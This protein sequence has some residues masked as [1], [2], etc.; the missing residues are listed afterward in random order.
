MNIIKTLSL[1]YRYTFNA[2][3]K[4]AISERVRMLFTDTDSFFLQFFMEDLANKINAR[5]HF[6]DAVDFSEISNGSLF[7]L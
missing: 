6:Q 1:L 7:N 5:F 3:L 4:D 2:L